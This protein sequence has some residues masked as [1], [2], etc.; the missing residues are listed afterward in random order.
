MD[1]ILQID[2]GTIAD[3]EDLQK[4]MCELLEERWTDDFRLY[5][6]EGVR[7]FEDDLC[8]MSENDILYIAPQGNT[9]F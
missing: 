7:Q 4:Q 6:K 5:D 3:F 8:M 2:Y 9:P 1:Q